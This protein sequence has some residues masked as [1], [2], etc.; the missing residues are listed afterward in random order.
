MDRETVLN[1]VH[2]VG[3]L[4]VALK[5]VELF[6]T[7]QSIIDVRNGMQDVETAAE[8]VALGA[9]EL[10]DVPPIPVPEHYAV[11]LLGDGIPVVPAIGENEPSNADLFLLFRRIW[12]SMAEVGF[13]DA[14]GGAE[15]QR[16]LQL[17]K[18]E[19]RPKDI[20]IFLAYH[21]NRSAPRK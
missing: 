11:P 12:C 15:S 21:I 20:S 14:W 8:R 2:V 13:C 1:L 16:L 19:N 4:L 18:D 9:A 6:G 10:L 7:N 3:K 5:D 17:W